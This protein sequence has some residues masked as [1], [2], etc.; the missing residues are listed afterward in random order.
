MS[1]LLEIVQEAGRLIPERRL[2]PSSVASKGSIDFVT[3]V[4]KA[5]ERFICGKVIRICS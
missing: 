2:E 5:V 4:D 3:D 1:V